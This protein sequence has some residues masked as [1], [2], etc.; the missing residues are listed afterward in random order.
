MQIRVIQFLYSRI[1]PKSSHN[2]EMHNI[3]M[4]IWKFKIGARAT[5]TKHKGKITLKNNIQIGGKIKE[6]EIEGT[7]YKYN[8]EIGI[9]HATDQKI[10]MFLNIS[11]INENCALIMYDTI[12]SNGSIAILHGV[13]N[14]EDCIQCLDETKKYKTGNI[15]M[16]IMMRQ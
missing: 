5:L 7:K 3:N 9:P 12:K 13:L 14:D 10:L 16:Q 8:V 6:T 4:S 11:G 2:Q 1:H 15:L